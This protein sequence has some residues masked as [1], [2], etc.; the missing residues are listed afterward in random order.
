M[1]KKID[2]FHFGDCGLLDKYN[3]VK[4][5]NEK[6]ISELL[7]LIASGNQYEYNSFDLAN[8]LNVRHEIIEQ[9]LGKLN[10]LNMIESKQGY[11][12]ICFTIFLNRDINYIKEI[13]KKVAHEIGD[14]ILDNKTEILDLVEGMKIKENFDANRILYHL[15]GDRVFDGVALDYFANK[16]LF[17]IYKLQPDNRNYI[18]VAYESSDEIREFSKGLLCSSNNKKSG[19]YCF[20]SFGDGAGNRK[21]MYRFLRQNQLAIDKS[22]ANHRLNEIYNEIND[23]YNLKLLNTFGE[24]LEKIF[25]GEYVF[26]VY[27][28]FM[29]EIGYLDYTQDNMIKIKVPVFKDHDREIQRKIENLVLEIIDNKVCTLF[30]GKND[31]LSNLTP[32]RHNVAIEE[33][34][35]ELWHLVF[36]EINEYLIK[37]EFFAR[38]KCIDNQ[39]SFFQSIYID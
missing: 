18:L 9:K 3:P 36:G 11:Y 37:K 20:N 21:D 32:V 10:E 28:D 22:T 35:N 33:I 13:S 1:N 5:Y 17:S 29:R 25:E 8:I 2:L 38:P 6:Y 31:I 15:I 14:I 4:L 19:K 24:R 27:S 23:K 34:S 7:Y 39:G 16:G 12:R 26:D 30:Q